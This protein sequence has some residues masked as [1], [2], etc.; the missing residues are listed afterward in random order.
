MSTKP[1]PTASPNSESESPSSEAAD[2]AVKAGFRWFLCGFSLLGLSVGYFAGSSNSPVIG[3]IVPLLFGLVGG[4]GGFYLAGAELSSPGTAL[5]LRFL[6]IALTAFIVP[7]LAG[8][9]YGVL[10]RTGLGISSFVPSMFVPAPA[11]LT[12]LEKQNTHEAIQLVL[13]R[14]RLRALK[15]TDAEQQIILDRIIKEQAAF[16]TARN[17]ARTLNSLAALIDRLVDSAPRAADKLPRDID[18]LGL[19]LGAYS[20]DLKR[21]AGKAE[22]GEKLSPAFLSYVV[23]T[24]KTDLDRRMDRPPT[25]ML[26]FLAENEAFRQNLADLRW[27]LFEEADRQSANPSLGRP[28]VIQEVDHFIG[29]LSAGAKESGALDS[30]PSLG[31]H[32]AK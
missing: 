2:Q 12:S 17:P 24:I 31:P 22:A 7:L 26:A 10:L 3:V 18:I 28:Q 14:A 15:A 32:F 13:T 21:F 9:V 16:E 23:G 8:S 29:L 11:P 25:E 30:K 20:K 19:Y 5:R 1:E 27:A 6:G 4:G